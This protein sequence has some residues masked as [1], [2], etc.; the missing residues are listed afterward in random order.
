LKGIIL[1]GGSGTR[2]FPITEAVSKQL[3][4]VYDKPMIYYPLSTLMLAGIRDI[5]IVSTPVDLP[6]YQRLLGDGSKFGISLQY[7][8]QPKP[9]GLAQAFLIGKEFLN[10]GPAALIL[11]DNLFY[12]HGISAQLQRAAARSAGATVFGYWVS[13]P[14]RYGVVE[15]DENNRV[16]SIE[17]KPANPRSNYAVVGLYFYDK[18][19]SSIAETIRP[20]ARGELEITEVNQRYLDRGDLRVELLGRG[21]AWLDTGTQESLLQAGNFVETIELRQGLK[22]GC[23]EEV[24]F[25]MQWLNASDLER[26]ASRYK[27]SSYGTY[28]LGLAANNATP[29]SSGRTGRSALT[30]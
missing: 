9:E 7:A 22:I 26:C 30:P 27:N 24:A 2:L 16:V 8:E 29:R 12:G 6:S 11:G 13:D 18:D 3:L 21:M 17:E 4:P 15:L 10:G 23:P 28:L 20:S 5:L 25:N 19:I 1:A 14:E